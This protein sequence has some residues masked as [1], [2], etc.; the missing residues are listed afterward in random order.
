MKLQIT[1]RQLEGDWMMQVGSSGMGAGTAGRRWMTAMALAGAWLCTTAPA[2]AGVNRWTSVGPAGGFF[3]LA[4][5]PGAPGTVYALSGDGGE[6][7]RKSTR[8]NSSH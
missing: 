6:G 3:D 2:S 8:L 1:D 5:A 4:A 7:D